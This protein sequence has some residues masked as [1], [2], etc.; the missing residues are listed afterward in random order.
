MKWEGATVEARD[1]FGTMR[2]SCTVR[3]SA[4]PWFTTACLSNEPLLF[5]LSSAPV[6]VGR[7]WTRSK[8]TGVQAVPLFARGRL[9][10]PVPQHTSPYR[11]PLLEVPP[12]RKRITK[13][14]GPLKHDLKQKERLRH[15]SQ[16]K[17]CESKM[18]ERMAIVRDQNV[19]TSKLRVARHC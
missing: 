2:A 1:K 17:Q 13:K 8:R 7:N 4:Q 12:K 6:Q 14:K 10:P 18:T 15:R 3:L 16:V 19:P 9:T 5:S 11:T